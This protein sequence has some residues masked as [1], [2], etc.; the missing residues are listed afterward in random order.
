MYTKFNVIIPLKNDIP[1][2]IK[3]L[4][5]EMIEY[6][7]T[8]SKDESIEHEFFNGKTRPFFARCNSYYFTGTSNSSIQYA[9]EE[10]KKDMVLH[11][12]CDFK[13]Y[14]NDID[15]FLDFVKQFIEYTNY[16][17]MFLGYSQY[18]EDANPTL[19]FYDGKE[20]LKFTNQNI[21]E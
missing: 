1:K 19:Y 10:E 16:F 17:P 21:Q 20:I 18:E 12:D 5:Y 8:S 9:N 7:T 6:G 14:N 4:L 13:N 15:L 11:I 2:N 3:E